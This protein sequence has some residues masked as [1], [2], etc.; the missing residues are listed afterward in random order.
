MWVSSGYLVVAHT[1]H[2]HSH[3][4]IFRRNLPFTSGAVKLCGW[5]AYLRVSFPAMA[6][7]TKTYGSAG[8]MVSAGYAGGRGSQDP[9]PPPVSLEA[10]SGCDD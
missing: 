6:P 3:V 7:K 1:H 10:S 8:E 2:I 5:K 4:S 9:P